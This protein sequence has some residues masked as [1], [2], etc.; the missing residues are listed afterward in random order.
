MCYDFVLY[1]DWNLMLYQ[2]CGRVLYQVNDSHR[3][4]PMRM[5][6]QLWIWTCVVSIN[7]VILC[8]IFLV[9][10]TECYKYLLEHSYP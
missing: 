6:L 7:V 8:D 5:Y 10:V 4:Y 3:Q 1:R 9:M 2:E